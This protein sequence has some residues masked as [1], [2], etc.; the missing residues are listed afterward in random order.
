MVNRSELLNTKTKTPI[1]IFISYGHPEEEICRKIANVIRDR[2]HKVWFDRDSIKAGEEW[3]RSITEGIMQSQSV[4][5]MLSRHSVR[6]P[7]VCLNEMRIA[8]GVK[9]GNIRTI[10]LEPES[11]VEAPATL[12]DR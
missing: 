10:L 4:L 2:G 9:G 5:S 1:R 12:M 7:G 6:N 3:R 11:L 8:I